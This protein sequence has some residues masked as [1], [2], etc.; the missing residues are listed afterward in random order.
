MA[1]NFYSPATSI[2]HSSTD[3]HQKVF[4]AP[5][6]EETSWPTSQRHFN[7]STTASLPVTSNTNANSINDSVFQASSTSDGSTTPS[8]THAAAINQE[9][10]LASTE[11]NSDTVL[12][13]VCQLESQ[14]VLD[15]PPTVVMAN[16]I[17]PA[18]HDNHTRDTEDHH[19]VVVGAIGDPLQFDRVQQ[20]D[21]NNSVATDVADEEVASSTA[22]CQSQSGCYGVAGEP[23]LSVSAPS[24]YDSSIVKGTMS[25]S[26]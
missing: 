14:L 23:V 5:S 3:T 18:S 22:A 25:L 12:T 11:A 26:N 7:A 24:E 8:I 10:F 4:L 21:D 9:P 20:D 1:S 16:S 6:K 13:H 15:V 2:M 19:P 17:P